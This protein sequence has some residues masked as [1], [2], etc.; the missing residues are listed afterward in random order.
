VRPQA[1]DRRRDIERWFIHRGLPHFIEGYDARRDI[2]TRSIPALVVAYLLGGFTALDIE[3][4]TATRN[5][6]VGAGVVALAVVT[7]AVANRIRGHPL[8]ERPQKVGTAEL[9]VFVL[10]PSVPSLLFGH[11][12][13][14]AL[15]A[16]LVGMA[17]LAT[18]YVSTSYALVPLLRWAFTRLATLLAALGGLVARA[19]PLLMLIV[20]FSFL[21]AEVWEMA[22]TLPMVVYPF[23]IGLFMV[24]GAGFLISRLPSD[25]GSVGR[26]ESW[27]DVDAYLVGTPA[28]GCPLPVEGSPPPAGLSRRQWVNLALVSL[29]TQGV[30]ITLVALTMGVFLTVFGLFAVNETTVANW[31]G[32]DEVEVWLRIALGGHDLVLTPSLLQVAGFL[33]TFTGFYFT[34]VLVTDD[35]YRREFRDGVVTELREALAVRYAYRAQLEPP[36]AADAPVA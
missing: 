26:F 34:V 28:E 31:T 14:D 32:R 19:L 20:T 30:Q 6:A 10:G 22:G 4:W 17:V 12:W 35:G 7:W 36:P 16:V 1:G 33:A 23:V 11:Q 2:F 5:V 27:S 3:R 13:G 29:F 15:Q 21:S 24:A 9:V 18:I 25:I 8:L